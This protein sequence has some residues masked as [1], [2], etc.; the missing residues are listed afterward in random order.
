M[1]GPTLGDFLRSRRLSI[2]SANGEG[3][4]STSRRARGLRRE[5]VAVRVGVSVDYYAKIE[6]G[7][8]R[9][10]PSG[11][12]LNA[13]A[14]VLELTDVERE[15]V[16]DL[17]RFGSEPAKSRQPGVQGVQPGTLE[18]MEGLS[19]FPALL[20]GR[21]LD[22]LAVNPLG[23]MLL[24]DFAAMPSRER[25]A[26]RWMMFNERVRE[27]HESWY[28]AATGAIGMLRM[29]LARYPHDPKTL[30]L[31]EELNDTSDLFR[32]IW[33]E[34]GVARGVTSDSNLVRHPA[35]GPIRSSLRA[36]RIAD[37]PNQTLQL[38][39]PSSD[40][41]SQESMAELRRLST[42]PLR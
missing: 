13:I 5:D 7:S 15:H 19:D 4:I 37:D 8:R 34:R 41:A 2:R 38:L 21:G 32:K 36:V 23:R 6:Q 40:P 27:I 26:V 14:D 28:T 10:V 20:V 30:E 29:D 12:V 16:F 1:A 25:N 42:P 9:I 11:T 18:L 31:V 35:V 39:I 22:I 33:S 24:D 3:I 17:A